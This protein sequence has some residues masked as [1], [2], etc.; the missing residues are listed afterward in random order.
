ML[1]L[2]YAIDAFVVFGIMFLAATVSFA[3]VAAADKRKLR[4][5]APPAR[6]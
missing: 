6:K 3:G 1:V 2:I 4:D 5:A